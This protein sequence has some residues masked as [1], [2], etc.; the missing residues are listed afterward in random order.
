MSIWGVMFMYTMKSSGQEISLTRAWN[1]DSSQFCLS[2]TRLSLKYLFTMLSY[3]HWQESHVVFTFLFFRRDGYALE[4]SW[5]T[6]SRPRARNISEQ[7]PAC[8]SRTRISRTNSVC[9]DLGDDR[10]RNGWMLNYCAQHKYNVFSVVV[11]FSLENNLGR[12][13]LSPG[14]SGVNW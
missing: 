12:F 1:I 14:C 2:F 4:R 9:C 10:E 8:K 6:C 11:Y 5:P 3:S 13:F 7:H